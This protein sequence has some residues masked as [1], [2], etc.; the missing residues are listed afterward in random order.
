VWLGW[1]DSREWQAQVA[2]GE[3]QV[4]IDSSGSRAAAWL[5]KRVGTSKAEQTNGQAD[6][7]AD[8]PI[9]PN[10]AKIAILARLSL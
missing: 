2:S 7:Q 8:G 9:R 6:R 3:L 10:R 4:K 1:T 5:T